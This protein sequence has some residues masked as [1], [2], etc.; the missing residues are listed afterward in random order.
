[1]DAAGDE[2]SADARANASRGRT[3]SRRRAGRRCDELDPRA[4]RNVWQSASRAQASCAACAL[5]RQNRAAQPGSHDGYLAV[6]VLLRLLQVDRKRLA[7]YF[8]RTPRGSLSP[9]HDVS[10]SSIKMGKPPATAP[11]PAAPLL[12]SDGPSFAA[13]PCPTFFSGNLTTRPEQERHQILRTAPTKPRQRV[14]AAAGLSDWACAMLHLPAAPFRGRGDVGVCFRAARVAADPHLMPWFPFK[15]NAR[16]HGP[17]TPTDAPLRMTQAARSPDHLAVCLSRLLRASSQT[18][19]LAAACASYPCHARSA[20]TP[21]PL[22]CCLREL[23]V[24]R[25]ISQRETHEPPSD[26]AMHRL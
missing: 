10:I 19:L 16:D 11:L 17:M 6:C 13:P 2:A 25:P 5:P 12:A 1:M 23:P 21:T 4:H 14:T 24:P 15:C 18:P 26:L 9:K 22:D 3:C 7:L 20:N 8:H